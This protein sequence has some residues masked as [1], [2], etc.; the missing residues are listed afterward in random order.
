VEPG[1]ALVTGVATFTSGQVTDTATADSSGAATLSF[2]LGT[3]PV[4]VMAPV[5][6]TALS[7]SPGAQAATTTTFTPAP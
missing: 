2:D 1:C 6:V 5:T 4:G 7:T 3:A